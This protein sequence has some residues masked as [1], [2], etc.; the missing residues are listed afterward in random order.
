MAIISL[1]MIP[2]RPPKKCRERRLVTTY[3]SPR[4]LC[5]EWEL[6]ALLSGVLKAVGARLGAAVARD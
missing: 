4:S 3:P 5:H 6:F 1:R 2:F